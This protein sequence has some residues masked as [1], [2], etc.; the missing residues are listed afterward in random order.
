MAHASLK[1]NSGG[2]SEWGV[3]CTMVYGF[4]QFWA[5][6]K[7]EDAGFSP[8]GTPGGGDHRKVACDGKALALVLDNGGWE[9]QGVEST[10]SSSNRCGIVSASS[11]GSHH[12]PKHRRVAA[13]C[14]GAATRV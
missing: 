11:S 10:G 13:L 9:L 6:M 1:W 12:G 7:A 14:V 5:Q 3:V 4:Q 2:S 8:T